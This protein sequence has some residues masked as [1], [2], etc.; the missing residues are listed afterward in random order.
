MSSS[1][2]L[3]KRFGRLGNNCICIIEAIYMCEHTNIEVL[4]IDIITEITEKESIFKRSCISIF[5][6]NKTNIKNSFQMYGCVKNDVER[7]ETKPQY[8]SDMVGFYTKKSSFFE[9][10]RIV[11]EYIVPNLN[12]ETI[13]L[14]DMDLV[15]HC[16]G[17]DIYKRCH[18]AYYQPPFDFYSK[19]ILSKP[20]NKIYVVCEEKTNPLV[21]KILDT[22]KNVSVLGDTSYS[23][24]RH[25]GNYW[26]F[27]NDLSF[28]LSSKN[29]ILCNS[30][31]SPFI[32][33]AN[34]VL[35]N[36]YIPSFYLHSEKSILRPNFTREIAIWWS[37]FANLQSPLDSSDKFITTRVIFNNINVHI[38]N[39]DDYAKNDKLW[40]FKDKKT[41]DLLLTYF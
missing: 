41:L 24:D 34:K 30:S 21:H 38:L 6:S 3:N 26:G 13:E 2:T 14:D 15:I 40:D 25:G 7:I 19:I 17:G 5:K 29:V 31:L 9:R 28:L 11:H 4:N 10:H 22:Y 20:W 1:L 39:Y 35:K 36:A 37:D 16:R 12:T 18:K 32:L 27:R 33:F 8:K 23:A